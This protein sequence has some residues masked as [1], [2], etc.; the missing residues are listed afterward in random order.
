[1]D[2]YEILGIE[3]GAD[4]DAI[5]RAYF[6]LIRKYTP[7]KY[8]EK[9]QQIRRAYE[10]LR[11]F[12][13]HERPEDQIPDN[14]FAK[15]MMQQIQEYYRQHLFKDAAE[16]A[17]EAIRYYGECNGFLYYQAISQLEN[18]NAGKA[19][20]TFE[21]LVGKNP[22]DVFYAKELAMAYME[23]GYTKKAYAAF[24]KAYGMGCRDAEFLKMYAFN[25]KDNKDYARSLGL[26][27]EAIQLLSGDLKGNMP[28]LID[29]YTGA[30]MMSL[31]QSGERL[32][33]V[34]GHF[35]RFLDAA[36]PYM[37]DYEDD[38][39]R[40]F[41]AIFYAMREAHITTGNDGERIRRALERGFG[42]RVG[43]KKWN[44]IV[45]AAEFNQMAEDS[46][47]SESWYYLAEQEL[48]F[49]SDEYMD[50]DQM[51]RFARLD[52]QMCILEE[53]PANKS[54]AE[55][56]RNEYPA[57]YEAVGPFIERLE[58][59]GNLDYLRQKYKKEYDR[60]SRYFES[61][62]YEEKYGRGR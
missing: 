31:Q 5:K 56:I 37:P 33:E 36:V 18:G 17:A 10:D 35:Y 48:D 7:E 62:L 60:L 21:K 53:W 58:K 46:R 1:M 57:V 41:R 59:S 32:D 40:L 13:G 22:D 52:C 42:S 43:S 61:S 45:V 2:D 12:D 27:L 34:R 9:F 55:I 50:D 20:K 11:S 24:E 23:R 19:A 29:V 25:C 16:T 15:I 6:K 28:D 54:E 39:L 49:Y 47:I 4:A 38:L 26:L 14:P 44:E 30:F 3:K 8:P 51:E